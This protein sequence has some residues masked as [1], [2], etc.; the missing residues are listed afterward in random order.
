MPLATESRAIVYGLLTVALWSTVASAF[1]LALRHVSPLELLLFSSLAATV[2]LGAIVL[3]SWRYRELATWGSRDYRRSALLGFLNPAL[4]YLL[5]FEAYDRLPAQEALLL[6]FAWPVVLVVLSVVLLRQRIHPLAIASLLLS[7]CGVIIIATRGDPLSM[8]LENPTGVALALASTVVWSVYWIYS[9]QDE[10]DSVNR[11]FCNFLFGS[12]Y[13]VI[14]CL[15]AGGVEMP[16]RSGAIGILYVAAFEMA[17]AFVFWLQAL[18][19]ARNAAEVS[20]LVYLTPFL[21]LIVIHFAVGEDLYPST[22]AGLV[23]IVGG[24]AGEKWIG[25]RTSR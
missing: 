6:N 14:Y 15:F 13:L 7:F 25:Y 22:L 8:R 12:G 20:S 11:L 17:F 18:K 9:S 4:Y 16:G 10:R 21:S 3:L 2:M 1:N 23:L 5:L 24:I 19:L